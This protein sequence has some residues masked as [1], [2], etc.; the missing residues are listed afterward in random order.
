MDKLRVQV[1]FKMLAISIGGLT[2][3]SQG[4]IYDPFQ[5]CA[6]TAQVD[7]IQITTW[8]DSLESGPPPYRSL[9]RF[10]YHAGTCM[11]SQD[12][13]DAYWMGSPEIG[14][15]TLRP[16][17]RINDCVTMMDNGTK[18]EVTTYYA[19]TGKTDSTLIVETPKDLGRFPKETTLIR[20]LAK[21]GYDLIQMELRDG[22]GPWSRIM[23][24]SIVAKGTG[25]VIYTQGEVNAVTTCVADG[26]TY[27]CTPVGTSSDGELRKQ[28]WYLT[29]ERVD[30]LRYY[31]P[32]GVYL[33]TDKWFWS[34]RSINST[35]IKARAASPR[36]AGPGTVF[37]AAGRKLPEA[38]RARARFM[39]LGAPK[40]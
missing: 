19:A 14:N 36:M 8:V 15:C 1:G 17:G 16:G 3:L 12:V 35:A 28:V 10:A 23:Q 37:D 39:I 11:P 2:G 32:K 22:N 4:M 34:P 29:G 33:E 26:K 6:E 13:Y 5:T 7:S 21:T 38:E 20:Y 9:E 27:A 25:K 18:R 40:N 30:S 31:D 24:D